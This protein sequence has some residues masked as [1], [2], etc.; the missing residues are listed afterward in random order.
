MSTSSNH[1]KA[2]VQCRHGKHTVASSRTLLSDHVHGNCA[3]LGYYA[4]SSGNFLPTSRYNLSIPTSR[5]KNSRSQGSNTDYW[6]LKRGMIGCPETS[7]KNY[8]YSLRNGPEEGGSLASVRSSFWY[9]KRLRY[10][11]DYKI[12]KFHATGRTGSKM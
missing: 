9:E 3:L 1:T 11:R 2:F 7:V 4:V 6:L 12:L 8:N 5:V 10:W